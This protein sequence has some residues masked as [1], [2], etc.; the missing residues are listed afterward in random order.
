MGKKLKYGS[1]DALTSIA[2]I[3]NEA[4]EASKDKS[5]TIQT[6]SMPEVLGAALGAGAGGAIAFGLLY[7]LGTA[8]LS[9]VGITSGLAAAGAIVGGGMVAGIGVLTAP[10]ALLGIIGYAIISKNKR[11]QLIQAKEALLQEVMIKH[12]TLLEEMKDKL[13][14]T[15]E[16]LQYLQA[17]I[18]LLQAAKKDLQE[19]LA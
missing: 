7:F 15:E 6:S 8:G 10:V 2:N 13:N 9:A 19:D 12:D 1:L 17:L 16:R 11:K 5:R 3:V 4:A 18:L 14:L